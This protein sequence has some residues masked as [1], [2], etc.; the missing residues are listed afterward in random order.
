[1]VADLWETRQRLRFKSHFYGVQTE[2]K[3]KKSQNLSFEK[4]G[5][6]FYHPGLPTLDIFNFTFSCL[7][8][9][10]LPRNLYQQFLM[11]EFVESNN[12]RATAAN[13]SLL[14]HLQ[15]PDCNLYKLWSIYLLLCF[16]FLHPLLFLVFRHYSQNLLSKIHKQKR[17]FFKNLLWTTLKSN[18]PASWGPESIIL[19]I[20]DFSDVVQI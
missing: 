15:N 20:A 14:N 7:I 6:K 17:T 3:K 10:H 18:E 4:Q 11:N 5:V 2:Q 19:S 9:I 1:M 16:S 8:Y 13:G 12:N